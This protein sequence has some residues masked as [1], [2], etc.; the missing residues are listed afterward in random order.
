MKIK[1]S[2]CDDWVSKGNLYPACSVYRVLHV[3]TETLG[4][5][6]IMQNWKSHLHQVKKIWVVKIK[7]LIGPRFESSFT[8]VWYKYNKS[9]I[10]KFPHFMNSL[11]VHLLLPF[12]FRQTARDPYRSF[13][14]TMNYSALLEVQHS[15]FSLWSTCI[16]WSFIDLVRQFFIL[17]APL[18]I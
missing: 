13:V 6:S 16:L 10:L 12:N 2:N 15:L 11:I 1:C 5:I 14:S 4:V 9:W 7:F 8:G 17:L 3:K 18:L